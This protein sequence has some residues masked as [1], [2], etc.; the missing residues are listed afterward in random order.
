MFLYL[1]F[2]FLHILFAIFWVG[3]MLFL[4]LIILPAIKHLPE[5]KE[6]L[7]KSGLKFRYYGWVALAGLLLTG[8]HNMYAK[9]MRFSSEFLFH[10]TL[11]NLLFIKLI[12][13]I[14]IVLLLVIHDIYIGEKFLKN[15]SSDNET[16]TKIAKIS[17]RI[18]LI[19]SLLA[20]LVGLMISRGYTL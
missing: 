15:E 7:I 17:G 3:G 16:L 19:L 9:G 20:V 13:F 2:L 11:G 1:F 6:I 10:N 5:R 4:P 12:L 8:I 18:N 14:L